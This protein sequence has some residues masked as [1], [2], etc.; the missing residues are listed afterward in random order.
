MILQTH[1]K[2]CKNRNNIIFLSTDFS[3]SVLLS[4]MIKVTYHYLRNIKN[5]RRTHGPI[6]VKLKLF[7]RLAGI[8]LKLTLKTRATTCTAV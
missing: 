5:L 7:T 8:L 1:N 2:L 4:D 6:Q 3:N